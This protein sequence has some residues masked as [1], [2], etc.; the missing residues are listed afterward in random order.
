[1]EISDN[2]GV[3][4]IEPKF[5]YIANMVSIH[6]YYLGVFTQGLCMENEELPLAKTKNTS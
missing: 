2:P 4:E 5:K 3:N 6:N 1:M